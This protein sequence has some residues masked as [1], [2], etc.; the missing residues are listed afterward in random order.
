MFALDYTTQFK[1]DLKRA[2]KQGLPRKRLEEVLEQLAQNGQV[3][4]K[5]IPH[6]L[7][8]NWKGFWD[9]HISPDWLLIYDIESKIKVVRLVRTGT[10]AEL[11]KK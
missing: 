11:Y 3:D 4:K 6:K 8:G 2:D 10:H 1:K 5:Y 7:S 9:C